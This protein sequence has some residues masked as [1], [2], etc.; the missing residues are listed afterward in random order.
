MSDARD[1]VAADAEWNAGDLGCGE[2]VLEL[3]GRMLALRPS[4][5]L[6]LIATDP[7][8]RPTFRPGAA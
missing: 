1:P 6:R 5:V 8:R 7:A 4:G 3:R 2:L